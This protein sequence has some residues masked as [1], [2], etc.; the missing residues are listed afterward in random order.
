MVLCYWDAQ[1]LSFLRGY[2]D[3]PH[4]SFE[5]LLSFLPSAR[6]ISACLFSVPQYLVLCPTVAQSQQLSL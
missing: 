1:L 4:P 5:A 6:D 2:G 3:P